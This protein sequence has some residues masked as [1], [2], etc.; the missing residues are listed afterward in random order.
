MPGWLSLVRPRKGNHSAGLIASMCERS[1]S[2]GF[3][4]SDD[5]SRL[6]PPAFLTV[7]VF[8]MVMVS[9]PV[10]MPKSKACQFPH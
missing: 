7:S 4:K 10:A 2:R 6:P 8:A 3:E 1:G 5:R 9:W